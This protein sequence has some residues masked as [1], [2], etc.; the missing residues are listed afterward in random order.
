MTMSAR[1]QLEE[2]YSSN[3][4]GEVEDWID[5]EEEDLFEE[6]QGLLDHWHMENKWELPG[7]TAHDVAEFLKEKWAL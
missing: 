3:A 2:L 4:F 5:L 1:Q 7:I 6:C